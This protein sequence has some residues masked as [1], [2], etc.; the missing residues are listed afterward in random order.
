[1]AITAILI[2]HLRGVR[3]PY[4]HLGPRGHVRLHAS[5]QVLRPACNLSNGSGCTKYKRLSN[6]T[7]MRDTSNVG[8]VR[9]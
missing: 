6:L 9:L 8:M 2:L 1:M 5:H 7:K 4:D 3:L